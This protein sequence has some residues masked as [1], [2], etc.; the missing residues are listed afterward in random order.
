MVGTGQE[1]KTP[2]NG[3]SSPASVIAVERALR[4]L[5]AVAEA[6]D[7]AGVTELAEQLS[8]SAPQIYRILAT[9]T[10]FGY[11]Y[12][13]ELSQRYRLSTR[14]LDLGF[15]SLQ[16]VGFYDVVMPVLRRAAA[17]AQCLVDLSWVEN[18]R[19][20]VVARADSPKTVKV[21]SPLGD[22]EIYHATA[23]G[24]VWLAHMPEAEAVRILKERGTPKIAQNTMTDLDEILAHFETIRRQGYAIADRE[25]DDHVV[26]V[27]API[28]ESG[29]SNVVIG[30]VGITAPEFDPIHRDPAMIEL[31]KATANEIGRIWPLVT[32]QP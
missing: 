7:G 9:L 21:S 2:P 13:D 23:S 3:V 26:A 1:L 31:A 25:W 15:R 27:S 10:A 18:G 22:E 28:R 24:K 32:L 6:R 14:L 29:R 5:E 12:K 11:V 8:I 4:V 30:A 16:L 20:V 19:M 17:K